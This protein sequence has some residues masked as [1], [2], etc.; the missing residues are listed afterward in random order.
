MSDL[1][2]V[3]SELESKN[4]ELRLSVEGVKHS[5]EDKLLSPPARPAS[6]L[7]PPR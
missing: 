1:Q 2:K 4:E 5:V 7:S 3:V 6:P